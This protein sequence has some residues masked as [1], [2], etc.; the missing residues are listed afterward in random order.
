M[1]KPRKVFVSVL[2]TGLYKKCKYS[3]GDSILP[4]TRFIQK[5]TLE[6]IGATGWTENDKILIFTTEKAKKLNWDKAITERVTKGGVEPNEGLERVLEDMNLKAKVEAVDIPEGKDEKEMWEVFARIYDKLEERDYLYFDLTHA[7]RY[8]P[9]LVLVLGQYARHIKNTVVKTV[10]YGNWEACDNDTKIAPIVDLMPLVTLQDYTQ[11]A[12]NFEEYG[13]M[14]AIG[15]AVIDT[16]SLA[17]SKKETG[18]FNNEAKNLNEGFVRLNDDLRTCRGYDLMHATAAT[19]IRNS[20]AKL[21]DFDIFPS[22]V[23]ELMGK[24]DAKLACFSTDRPYQ[25]LLN[26]VDWC[27]EYNL[28]QQGYTLCQETILTIVCD[29]IDNPFSD[30]N[31][32][33]NY[34][35][36]RNF[37]SSLL[38]MRNEMVSDD[39]K[40]SSNLSQHREYA[41]SLLET[42]EIQ[43]LRNRYNLLKDFRN[44][45]NHGG[46]TNKRNSKDLIAKFP[47]IMDDSLLN[48]ESF[49][50]SL[51]SKFPPK[52]KVLINLSNHPYAAWG[53][54]QRKAAEAYGACEDMPFPQIAPELTERELAMIVDSYASAVLE[55]AKTASVTV[56]VMGEMT[57]CFALI[58]RLKVDGIS[59]IASCTSRNV[60]ELDDHTRQTTFTFGGF[61]RYL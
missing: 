20:L 22:P 57:F 7:F 38:G 59:C 17:L 49:A 44:A 55:R 54:D 41:K 21:R 37:V 60:V 53:E 9:M 29:S 19:N 18:Q 11:A 10:T 25:N 12:S 8:L 28:V 15:Q 39:N 43:E 34:L 56:H 45:I 48:I 33:D 6:M 2:G 46:F 50:N 5:A 3:D 58:Q 36:F 4:E 35:N 51:H 23:S 14:Q 30:K 27:K 1:G 26:V 61:R 47:S 31:D 16:D 42:D 40:W 52:P 13:N 32:K 24:V